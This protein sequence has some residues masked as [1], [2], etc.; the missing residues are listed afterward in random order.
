[1]HEIIY[2]ITSFNFQC[3]ERNRTYVNLQA[4][5]YDILWWTSWCSCNN[6]GLLKTSPHVPHVYDL[7][8]ICDSLENA[9]NISDSIVPTFSVHYRKDKTNLTRPYLCLLCRKRF[10]LL[11]ILKQHFRQTHSESQINTKSYTC[12]TCGDV[13]NSPVLLQEH[14]DVHHKIS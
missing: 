3:R 2:I 8:F 7:V 13:F 11:T 5:T 10:R 14:H 4:Q 6:T 1:M 9:N 12:A